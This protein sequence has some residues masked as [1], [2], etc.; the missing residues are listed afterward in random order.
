MSEEI[1]PKQAVRQAAKDLE[2]LLASTDFSLRGEIAQ[3]LLKLTFALVPGRYKGVEDKIAKRIAVLQ[4]K[5]QRAA[6]HASPAENGK[7]SLFGVLS[8]II[9]AE[10]GVAGKDLLYKT[11]A[12]SQKLK[13]DAAAQAYL[14]PRTEGQRIRYEILDEAKLRD[15]VLRLFHPSFEQ[16]VDEALAGTQNGNGAM[17]NSYSLRAKLFKNPDVAK[18]ITR[19]GHGRGTKYFISNMK[20]LKAAL[21]KALA[22]E[23]VQG[24]SFY[25]ILQKVIAEELKVTGKS[26]LS[27]TAYSQQK[28][29]DD[30]AVAGQLKLIPGKRTRYEVRDP[31][32]LEARLRTLVR[33]PAEAPGQTMRVS[34]FGILS[35]VLVEERQLSGKRLQSK[36]T[37][38]LKKFSKD[39]EV[40][41]QL[42]RPEGNRLYHVKDAAALEARLRALVRCDQPMVQKEQQTFY[43]I[44]K[45]V[46]MEECGLDAVAAAG[47]ASAYGQ[48]LKNE[49]ALRKYATMPSGAF[50]YKVKNAK[51]LETYLRKW[52]RRKE[53][54]IH[55]QVKAVDS[56]VYTVNDLRKELSVPFEQMNEYLSNP[57]YRKMLGKLVTTEA[58]GAKRFGYAEQNAK[59]FLEAV[60]T[61]A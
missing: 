17:Q 50:R 12:L 37:Y 51:R 27:K 15:H 4:R 23:R 20:A 39:R 9:A 56:R 18:H 54:N 52:V 53:E 29:A 48:E 16:V 13:K 2:N 30:N 3:E 25:S 11:S 1:T 61:N 7:P 46:L 24:P 44:L 34:Y 42:T 41:A 33:N 32:A 26:L 59:Q 35:K 8:D 55:P 49:P 47:K 60:R 40:A 38:L 6:A 22:P 21:R 10:F 5:A 28:F 57:A 58:D 36:L 14:K 43:G 31:D 45:Q 19:T